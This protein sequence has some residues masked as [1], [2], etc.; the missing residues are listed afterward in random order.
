MSASEFEEHSGSKDRRPADGIFMEGAAR[1]G[2]GLAW[3]LCGRQRGDWLLLHNSQHSALVP[4]ASCM[5]PLIACLTM[6]AFP[7]HLRSKQPQPQGAAEPD[8]QP[9]DGH[10]RL[11]ERSRQRLQQCRLAAR[12]G[13]EK[14]A[15]RL[16]PPL[17]YA[18]STVVAM[19]SFLPDLCFIQL[20]LPFA[21]LA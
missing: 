9:R 17:T 13:R 16:P 10:R 20:L 2:W 19:Q 15:T 12:S 4:V 14:R 3:C 18:S 6:H 5:V 8:Q 7:C 21:F 1:A 11:G